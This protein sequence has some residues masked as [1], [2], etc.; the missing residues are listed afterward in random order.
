MQRQLLSHISVTFLLLCL[1]LLHFFIVV[2]VVVAFFLL[3][4]LLLLHFFI[5][6]FVVNATLIVIPHKF[7]FFLLLCL[8]LM[9]R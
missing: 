4:C 1:S 2:F 3:L 8:L 7:H 5:V 9:Q 6:V